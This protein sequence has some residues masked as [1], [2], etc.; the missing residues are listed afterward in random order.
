M[1]LQSGGGWGGHHT[2]YLSTGHLSTSDGMWLKWR[3]ERRAPGTWVRRGMCKPQT[4]SLHTNSTPDWSGRGVL[5]S[6]CGGKI[7]LFTP[8]K[9]WV[10]VETKSWNDYLPFFPFLKLNLLERSGLIK[11]YRFQLNKTSP[12]H[13]SCAHYPK[14]SL[15]PSSFIFLLAISPSFNPLS[16]AI[17]IL[18]SV[19]MCHVHILLNLF[20]FFHLVPQGCL[21]F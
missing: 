5:Y 3:K 11:P 21:H 7:G 16:S 13:V 12:A 14:S 15:F 18:L 4:C 8:Q 6:V 20:T 1:L 2:P 9:W 17:T 10:G 19:C